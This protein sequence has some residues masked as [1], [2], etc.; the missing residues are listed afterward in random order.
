MTLYMKIKNGKSTI[1]KKPFDG[2]KAVEVL[3]RA[4]FIDMLQ[5]FYD[6]QDRGWSIAEEA[7]K[8]WTQNGDGPEPTIDSDFVLTWFDVDSFT[9][10]AADLYNLFKATT[11][12]AF[13]E[14]FEW[15]ETGNIEALGTTC[16][17]VM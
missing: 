14:I 3:P 8:K 4:D 7:I 2:A 13:T 15:D 5:D 11:I 6:E 10:D 1:K 16:Y 17:C 9:Q 12:Y